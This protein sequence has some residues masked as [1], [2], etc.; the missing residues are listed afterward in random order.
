MKSVRLDFCGSDR[1]KGGPHTV[2]IIWWS[3]FF[4]D[5]I[6]P[7]AWFDGS[8]SHDAGFSCL[9]LFFGFFCFGIWLFCGFSELTIGAFVELVTNG[10]NYMHTVSQWQNGKFWLIEVPGLLADKWDHWIKIETHELLPTWIHLK[11][12]SD[13]HCWIVVI[14]FLVGWRRWILSIGDGSDQ[15]TCN[16]CGVV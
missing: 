1:K 10:N 7:T 3:S 16:Y 8:G 13:I 14:F 11:K 15:A 6:D 9:F 12:R 2:W 5:G 4:P